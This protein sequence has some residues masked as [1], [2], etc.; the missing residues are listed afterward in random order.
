[1]VGR[2]QADPFAPP[3]RCRLFLPNAV[4]HLPPELFRNKIRRI[5]AADY[6]LRQ[7]YQNCKRMGADNTL[8]KSGGGGWSGPKGGDIQVLE[9]TQHVIEQSAVQLDA[10][11]HITAQIT[12]NLPARGR[13]I[14]GRA[15]DEILDPILSLLIQ[16]S[17]LFE[18]LSATDLIGH[19]ESVDDQAWLQDQLDAAGLVAF[20]RN[21]AILPRV[22]GVD[23]RPMTDGSVISF[24]S[25]PSRQVSFRLPNAGDEIQGMGV[26]KGITLICGG[27][28]HGKST[29]LEALQLGVYWKIPGDGREFCLTSPLAVKIR[30]EDGRFVQTVDI[31]PFINNLPFGKDTT[32]FSTLD[33]SGSTSQATNIVEVSSPLESI[34]GGCIFPLV[35]SP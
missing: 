25:P 2:A 29:L 12:V 17:F 20:V 14:L 26:P 22:S 34:H 15:A 11:G 7:L 1:M 33:A 21:G 35:S 18:S 3:T 24:Q 10:H 9:P 16:R 5:A 28:F 30:A 13:T 4:S 27:G 19:V 6:L 32:C 31:S 8:S 23:D